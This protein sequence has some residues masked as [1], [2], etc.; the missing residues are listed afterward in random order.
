MKKPGRQLEQRLQ[1]H[2]PSELG[3]IGQ[4][5]ATQLVKMAWKIHL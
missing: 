1:W 4:P 5:G 3:I 2:L